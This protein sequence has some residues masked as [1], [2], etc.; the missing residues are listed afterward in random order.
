M[1]LYAPLARS[2]PHR[3]RLRPLRSAYFLAIQAGWYPIGTLLFQTVSS[4]CLHA[5][6][7]PS[8]HLGRYALFTVF[9]TFITNFYFWWVYAYRRLS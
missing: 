6:A 4:R 3:Q 8:L 1:P 7:L 9:N 5:C 2:R